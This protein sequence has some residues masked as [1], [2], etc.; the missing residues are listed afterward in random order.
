MPLRQTDLSLKGRCLMAYD[1]LCFCRPCLSVVTLESMF[2]TCELQK[3]HSNHRNYYCLIFTRLIFRLQLLKQ[4]STP[5]GTPQENVGGCKKFGKNKRCLNG[6]WHKNWFKTKFIMNQ[7]FLIAPDHI[8]L[9][10]FPTALVLTQCIHFVLG[11]P[12]GL[13]CQSSLP[14]KL[15]LIHAVVIPAARGMKQAEFW[16]SWPNSLP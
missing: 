2:L 7:G 1:L 13:Q 3:T 8:S 11:R 15:G 9:Y 4:G 12:S 10:K 6:Q 5:Y 14:G 16:A